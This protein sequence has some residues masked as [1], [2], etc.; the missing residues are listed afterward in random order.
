MSWKNWLLPIVVAT[1]C[2]CQPNNKTSQEES[3]IN[4]AGGYFVSEQDASF[5]RGHKLDEDG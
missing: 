1:L 5:R 2:S 4:R 3:Q